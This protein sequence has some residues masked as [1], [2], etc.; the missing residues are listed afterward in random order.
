[1]FERSEWNDSILGG[2]N[3]AK[4]VDDLPEQFVVFEAPQLLHRMNNLLHRSGFSRQFPAFL[5]LRLAGGCSKM[6]E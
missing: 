1:M 2:D 5:R 4:Y 6:K 3:D